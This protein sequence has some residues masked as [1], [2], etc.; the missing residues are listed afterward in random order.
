MF[1]LRKY[2]FEMVGTAL[3]LFFSLGMTFAGEE[4]PIQAALQ[5]K[6][7]NLDERTILIYEGFPYRKDVVLKEIHVLYVK[8]IRNNVR[9]PLGQDREAYVSALFLLTK[10][11]KI[12][13]V[14]MDPASS[15]S[16]AMKGSSLNALTA[17]EDKYPLVPPFVASKDYPIVQGDCNPFCFIEL[18]D[19]VGTRFVF[20]EAG[21]SFAVKGLV[22]RIKRTGASMEIKDGGVLLTD[23]E[24]SNVA[25]K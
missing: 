21:A 20:S 18:S 4:T 17:S 8:E 15:K 2:L 3:V 9:L 10:G 6:Y 19:A 11:S 22:F 12:P 13:I 25:T 14:V 5:L 24:L 16:G 23:F 1:T 7:R